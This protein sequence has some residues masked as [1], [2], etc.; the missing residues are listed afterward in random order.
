MLRLPFLCVDYVT[1]ISRKRAPRQT[2]A[3]KRKS[4]PLK[5]GFLW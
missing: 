3:A 1:E 4:R 5:D 2:G